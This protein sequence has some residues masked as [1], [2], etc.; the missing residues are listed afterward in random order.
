MP[1]EMDTATGNFVTP[2]S[3]RADPAAVFAYRTGVSAA[4][5]ATKPAPGSALFTVNPGFRQKCR[6]FVSTTGAPTGCTIRPYLR[7]G[8]ASGQVG[9][10]A[11]QTLNGTPNFDLSFDVVT[12]G[13]DLA[14]LVE[15]LSGGTTP[16]VSISL[17]WR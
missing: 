2:Q 12:D 5:G 7:A 14:L 1:Q 11:V 8:G 17:S 4:D 10:A 16:T 6:V 9:S 15:T 3:P 13:D